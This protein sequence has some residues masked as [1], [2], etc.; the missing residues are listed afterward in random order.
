M[1]RKK[2]YLDYEQRTALLI[3]MAIRTEMEDFHAENLTNDQM[4]VLNP[5]IR[6][7]VYTMLVALERSPR[8][9]SCKAF[10]NL[11]LFQM[12]E[13]WENPTLTKNF[14]EVAPET[15]RA[16]AARASKY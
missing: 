2:E 3:A 6:N 4:Q 8:D 9:E 5:L 14:K 12:P 16:I 13:E 10:V 15:A 1:F 11:H 7:A